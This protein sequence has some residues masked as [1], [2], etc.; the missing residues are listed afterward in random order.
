MKI[1]NKEILFLKNGLEYLTKPDSAFE[2]LYI[3]VREK[4]KRIYSDEELTLLPY[5]DSKHQ[6]AKEWKLRTK[7]VLR[8]NKY[9]IK[10]PSLNSFLELG[11][12]NG[13]FS[14][15]LALLPQKNVI[16]LDINEIELTQAARVFQRDRLNFYYGNIFENFFKENSFDAILLNASVQYF[17]HFKE[18]INH[19]F[20]YLKKD[21]EIHILDTPFY[22]INEVSKA[23]QRSTSYYQKIGAPEMSLF[24]FHR[25]WEELNEFNYKLM[26]NPKKD[27][28]KKIFGMEPSPFPW[29]IIHK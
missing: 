19:L 21:G 24:Y 8:I 12:G 3:E 15:Q 14:A 28:W 26:Y 16:G 7:T 9:L 22:F 17:P 13:W 10:K 1:L 25:N 23:H 5:I 20:F 27:K 18:L 11:C 2:R 4:E 29:I 6:Y